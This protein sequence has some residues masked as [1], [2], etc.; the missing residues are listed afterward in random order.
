MGSLSEEDI[1]HLGEEELI[2][3]GRK[4]SVKNEIFIKIIP[5]YIGIN[6][7]CID[8]YLKGYEGVQLAY[9]K[10]KYTLF[11]RPNNEKFYKLF[12]KN[13]VNYKFINAGDFIKENKIEPVSKKEHYTYVCRWDPQHEYLM[14]KN[15]YQNNI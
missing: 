4:R 3:T 2:W 9:L 14:V 11:I 7:Y 8:K 5:P 15:V 6:N 10:D 1:L 12:T 13:N